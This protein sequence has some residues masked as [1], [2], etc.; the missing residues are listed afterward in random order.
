MFAVIQT[1]AKQYKVEK[2]TQIAVEKLDAK[3]GSEI[4]LENV[5]LVDDK[6]NTKVGTPLVEGASV[7][8]K[9]LEQ[10]KADKIKVFKMKPKKR[11]Q[12][13]QGHRQMQTV[14]EITD[15]KA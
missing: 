8:A 15:I 10:G 9:V 11:Y 5:L 7:K 3:E 6:G 12:K 1:G 4:T 2:G 14:L 13:T